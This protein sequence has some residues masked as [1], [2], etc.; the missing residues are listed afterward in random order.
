VRDLT[1]IRETKSPRPIDEDSAAAWAKVTVME[2]AKAWVMA[3]AK[4]SAVDFVRRQKA[5]ARRQTAGGRK[6]K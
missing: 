1:A 3:E 4:L 5:G 2:K 6:Q